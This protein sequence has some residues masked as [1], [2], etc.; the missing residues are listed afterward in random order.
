MRR[1]GVA[2]NYVCRKLH[3]QAANSVPAC[4]HRATREK[5]R[6]FE[7]PAQENGAS[8]TTGRPW[9]SRNG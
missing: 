4:E 1:V 8:L 6:A 5:V 2:A 3:K 7:S 9:V